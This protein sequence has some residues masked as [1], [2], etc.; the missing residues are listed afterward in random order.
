MSYNNLGECTLTSDERVAERDRIMLMF[1]GKESIV[2]HM[3]DNEISF[4]KKI[5]FSPFVT[6]K[7]LFWLRDIWSKYGA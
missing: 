4:L 5:E 7:Q 1:E 3:N 6:I 2:E